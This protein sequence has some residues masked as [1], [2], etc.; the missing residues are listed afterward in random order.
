MWKSRGWER[1]KSKKGGIYECGLGKVRI[2]IGMGIRKGNR[3]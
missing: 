1:N 3:S 2:K